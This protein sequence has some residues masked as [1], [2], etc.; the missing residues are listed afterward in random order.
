M[1]FDE[2]HYFLIFL[3]QMKKESPPSF[4]IVRDLFDFIDIRKDGILDL[5]EWM[6]TFRKIEKVKNFF[7]FF[8]KNYLF[9]IL[10]FLF[11]K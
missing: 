10:I 8:L 1:T 11:N 6:Q 9:E 3:S 7:F 4:N 5:H 2:F